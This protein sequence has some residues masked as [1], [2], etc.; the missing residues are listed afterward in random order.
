M[1]KIIGVLLA[2]LLLAVAGCAP[3]GGPQGE[4]DTRINIAG[5][6]LG[7]SMEEVR[8]VLGSDFTEIGE[9]GGDLPA[10]ISIWEYPNG[11]TVIFSGE[12]MS[13]YV[14]TTA[15]AE[16][17]TSAG[18]TVGE[19]MEAALARYRAEYTEMESRHSD[20]PL[21]GWFDLGD[22]QVLIFD[23]DKDDQ[24]WVNDPVEPGDSVEAIHLA[25]WKFF[26]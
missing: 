4:E 14:V 15:A 16:Q 21:A 7:D 18:D 3:G 11:I 10:P 2:V 25:Q 22:G 13:V 19:G 24:T 5:V 9:D 23:T 26:D 6:H 8:E 20:D 12:P 17:P 1:R